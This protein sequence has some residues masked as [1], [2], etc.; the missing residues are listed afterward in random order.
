MDPCGTPDVTGTHSDVHPFNTTRWLRLCKYSRNQ[1]NN[2]PLK[3][4][5]NIRN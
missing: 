5:E 2:I 3:P 1:L 4:I